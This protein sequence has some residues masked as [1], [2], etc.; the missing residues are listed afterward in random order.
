MRS[1]V[2]FLI[3]LVGTAMT[4]AGMAFLK[5][6]ADQVS[7][8]TWRLRLGV[9]VE[10]FRC[11]IWLL[12]TV[13]QFGSFGALMVA[14]A[15]APVTVVMPVWNSGILIFVFLSIAYLKER[16]TAREKLFV[17]LV[18][19]GLL[20]LGVSLSRSEEVS[21][22]VPNV[23]VALFC[24]ASMALA[25]VVVGATR[26]MRRV[27]DWG[28]GIGVLAGTLTGLAT[29]VQKGFVMAL[30]HPP[31][32]AEVTLYA[33]AVIVTNVLSYIML[34]GALQ[35]GKAINVVPVFSGLGGVLPILAG[36]AAFSEALPSSS[37][38]AAARVASIAFI[39]VGAL[40]LSRFSEAPE[41]PAASVVAEPPQGTA[42]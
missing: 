23:P 20:I 21:R 38:R 31:K 10:L 27:M 35:R 41:G 30:A 8:I 37:W 5:R 3:S 32:A 2:G 18:V 9:V 16:L 19:A 24:V 34:Q 28:L 17:T 36:F 11:R 33:I 39:V 13:L 4:H 29:V 25:L 26:R 1:Q 15:L 14:L 22:P 12:G 6:G 42:S 40:G 7:S